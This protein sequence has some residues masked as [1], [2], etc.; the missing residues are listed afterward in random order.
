M[1]RADTTAGTLGRVR[2]DAALQ[3][4]LAA[5]TSQLDSLLVDI[6]KHPL[7]YLFF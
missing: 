3:R 1:A 7:R 4:S 2:R 6:H 5:G